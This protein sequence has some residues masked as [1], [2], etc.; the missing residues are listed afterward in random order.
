MRMEKEEE[1]VE[2]EEDTVA[3]EAEAAPE[4]VDSKAEDQVMVEEEPSVQ[5][6]K[7]KKPNKT[8]D[9]LI[10]DLREIGNKQNLQLIKFNIC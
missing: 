8:R 7:T 1:E 9:W 10:C 2:E 3:I 4:E 5:T 6:Y